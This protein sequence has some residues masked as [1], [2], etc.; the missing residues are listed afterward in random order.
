VS[1]PNAI[2]SNNPGQDIILATFALRAVFRG[3]RCAQPSS[4]NFRPLRG[5]VCES[6]SRLRSR[7]WTRE[8]CDRELPFSRDW[9]EGESNDIDS[10]SRSTGR[11]D[12]LGPSCPTVSCAI[13]FGWRPPG[14]PIRRGSGKTG[15]PRTLTPKKC[16][17]AVGSSAQRSAPSTLMWYT[18]PERRFQNARSNRVTWRLR[19]LL[20]LRPTR[21]DRTCPLQPMPRPPGATL[22]G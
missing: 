18:N 4:T 6:G 8:F 9:S 13:R 1:A 5:V 17:R 14:I 22:R 15:I 19:F 7:V 11:V 20:D 16:R 3:D 2:L 10:E 21:F 12:R